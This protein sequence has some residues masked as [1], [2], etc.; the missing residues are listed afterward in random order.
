M[1]RGGDK[2]RR[3]RECLR[4]LVGDSYKHLVGMVWV[5]MEKM[6]TEEET[7]EEYFKHQ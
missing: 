2:R 7:G 5:R 4:V 1:V 6:T 3:E